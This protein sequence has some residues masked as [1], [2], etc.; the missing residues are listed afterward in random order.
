MDVLMTH[1]WANGY[2]ADEPPAPEPAKP[3]KIKRKRRK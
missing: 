2:V 3:V 1:L